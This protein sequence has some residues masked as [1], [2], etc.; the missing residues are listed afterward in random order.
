MNQE[1]SLLKS[2]QAGERSASPNMVAV[3]DFPQMNMH[4]GTAGPLRPL[5]P[6][7]NLD[8]GKSEDSERVTSWKKLQISV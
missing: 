8:H 6:R 2:V 4:L 3:L 7:C 1:D 5:N